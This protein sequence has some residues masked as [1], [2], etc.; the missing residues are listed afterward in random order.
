[1]LPLNEACGFEAAL[2]CA[3]EKL[4]AA[5]AFTIKQ[6]LKQAL[7]QFIHDHLLL[8]SPSNLLSV[9]ELWRRSN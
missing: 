6:G 1:M 5:D 8:H 4:D 7:E 9:S 3:R 2:W